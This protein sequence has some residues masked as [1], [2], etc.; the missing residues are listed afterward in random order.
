MTSQCVDDAG[1]RRAVVA[2]DSA[3]VRFLQSPG[4]RHSSPDEPAPAVLEEFALHCQIVAV[5]AL[6]WARAF[7]DALPVHEENLLESPTE[8]ELLMQA[9]RYA[10]CKG[11]HVLGQYTDVSILHSSV[12]AFGMRS[13]GGAVQRPEF[14]WCP[15]N[16]LPP[17]DENRKNE[18]GLRK[19]FVDTWSGRR[20]V[21]TLHEVQVWLHGGYLTR[22]SS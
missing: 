1:R 2:F 14:C 7:Y 15:E 8:E 6:T 10:A 16:S 13:Y 9:A 4:M 22:A 12:G 18:V 3:F 20:V 11:I 5:E 19:A 17:T 21:D